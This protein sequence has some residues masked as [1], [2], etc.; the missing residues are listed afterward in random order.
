MS[1]LIV[2][3]DICV[4]FDREFDIYELINSYEMSELIAGFEPVPPLSD[5]ELNAMFSWYESRN[6]H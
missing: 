6:S 1:N 5:D 4:E 3:T 2:N